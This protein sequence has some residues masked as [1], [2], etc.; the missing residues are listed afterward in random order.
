MKRDDVV[1]VFD[2]NSSGV[3]VPPD[4]RFDKPMPG[5]GSRQ[6]AFLVETL[7]VGS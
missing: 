5:D 2:K 7:S 3:H 6:R 1:G 4:I